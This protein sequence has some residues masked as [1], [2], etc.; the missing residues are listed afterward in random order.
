MLLPFRAG[1]ILVRALRCP[2]NWSTAADLSTT[3]ISPPTHVAILPDVFGTLVEPD[4][5]V[6]L[7]TSTAST[8]AVLGDM[9]NL[10][11]LVSSGIGSTS[12]VEEK[13]LNIC[14]VHGSDHGK[15]N[16]SLIEVKTR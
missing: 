9:A 3:D 14:L 8:P 15:L 7:C 11:G 2:D 5:L 4:R 10:S 6:T 16:G 13:I 12:T 1:V